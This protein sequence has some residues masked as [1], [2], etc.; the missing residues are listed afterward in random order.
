[1]EIKYTVF[2]R[3][4]TNWEQF[5]NARKTVIRRNL[6]ISEARQLCSSFND[7]RT[8]DQIRKGTKYE[9]TSN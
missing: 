8:P 3:S 5:T 4:A 6:T 9:F 7:N 1:M 2:R